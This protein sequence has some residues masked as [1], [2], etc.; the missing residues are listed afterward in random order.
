MYLTERTDVVVNSIYDHVWEDEDERKDALNNGFESWDGLCLYI[1]PMSV[2]M[3]NSRFKIY[4]YNEKSTTKQYYNK[5][6]IQK[7][8]NIK[9]CYVCLKH[10]CGPYLLKV[11]LPQTCELCREKYGNMHH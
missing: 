11:F 1:F 5:T 3:A 9:Y 6:E 8:M 10:L 2:P 7:N 4:I